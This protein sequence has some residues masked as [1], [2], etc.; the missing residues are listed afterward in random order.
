MVF[1]I[2]EKN[3]NSMI[4]EKESS[5]GAFEVAQVQIEKAASKMNLDPNILTQH[6]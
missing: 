6:K 4:K 1:E 2:K 3:I 5:L